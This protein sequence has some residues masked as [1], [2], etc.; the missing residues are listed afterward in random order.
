MRE[1]EEREEI[2]VASLPEIILPFC[3]GERE[4][5]R[6]RERMALR[7]I[8]LY[9]HL[10]LVHAVRV[11]SSLVLHTSNKLGEGAEIEQEEERYT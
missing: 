10:M 3:H 8:Q 11:T 2:P 5:E 9:D 4:R 7:E 6:E 1:R